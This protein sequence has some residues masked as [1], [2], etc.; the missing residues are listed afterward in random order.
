MTTTTGQL[1][2]YNGSTFLI[3]PSP[4]GGPTP[5]ITALETGVGNKA[6]TDAATQQFAAA[7]AAAANT[8]GDPNTLN[9]AANHNDN[10]DIAEPLTE[11]QKFKNPSLSYAT[12]VSPATINWLIENYETAEGV[13]LPRSTLYTHY[14]KHW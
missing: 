13:S 7:A 2:T 4:N 10:S 11:E 3:H 8:I 9:A 1:L 14:Q 5:L 12:R 6:L